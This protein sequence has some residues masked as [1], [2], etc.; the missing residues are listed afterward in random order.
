MKKYISYISIFSIIIFILINIPQYFLP[1]FWGNNILQSKL[2]YIDV[3]NEYNTLFIGSSRVNNQLIPEIFDAN[4]TNKNSFNLGAS[5]SGAFET[6]K[7][8]NYLIDN[9]DYYKLNTILCE[10]VTLQ[11]STPEKNENSIRGIYF[12]NKD[13]FTTVSTSILSSSKKPFSEKS[14]MLLNELYIYSRNIFK[15]KTYGPAIQYLFSNKSI[16]YKKHNRNKGYFALKTTNTSE[17]RK[18]F[19]N[20]PAKHKKKSADVRKYFEKKSYE[21]D[22]KIKDQL[23]EE[24][25]KLL[26]DLIT[27]ASQNNIDLRFLVFPIQKVESY[28]AIMSIYKTLPEKNKILLADP[29]NL[30]KELYAPKYV[31]DQV[32]LN[33]EGSKILTEKLAKFINNRTK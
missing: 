3:T 26:N 7:L 19:L 5:G 28:K 21:K 25:I 18:K 15:I 2:D 24:K 23:Y 10:F 32:H 14:K 29:F 6:I 9:N 33:H 12:I 31:Y 8:L 11:G 16:N 1:P 4:T 22:R 17:G 20:N 13:Y 30:G 27:K